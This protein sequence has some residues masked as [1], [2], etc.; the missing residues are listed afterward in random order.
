MLIAIIVLGWAVI[1]FFNY[2][3][4]FAYWQRKFPIQAWAEMEVG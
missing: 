2:G 1:G 4:T 3:V